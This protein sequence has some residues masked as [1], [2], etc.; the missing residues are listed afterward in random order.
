MKP[1]TWSYSKLKNFEA[2]QKRHQ[3]I[4][5][6]KN[7]QDAG[8]EALTW[9]NSV[10][11]AL[12]KACRSEARLPDEM[13]P[14]QS[15]VDRVLAGP[16]RLM[17]EQKYAITRAFGPCSGYFAPTVWYRGIADIVRVWDDVALV[18]DWKTGKV[19]E[20]SVQ[21]MLMAACVFAHFPQVRVVRSEFIWLAEDCTTPEI[22]TQP[23]VADA[24]VALLPRVEAMERA[25]LSNTYRPMP[26]RLCKRWCPVSNCEHFGK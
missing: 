21:L 18:I 16:G 19:L 24:W 1:F 3:Q 13:L 4:D 17:V 9:G 15:W 23:D 8:G 2:C 6:L 11:D 5:L 10:H 12:A 14:Y 20:D 22:Y 25:Y 26:G 7:F